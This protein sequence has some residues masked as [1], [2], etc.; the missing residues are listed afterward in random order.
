ML[1]RG[2]IRCAFC[3]A[4]HCHESGVDGSGGSVEK[5]ERD[6]EMEPPKWRESSE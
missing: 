5:A 3:K 1:P 2:R 6:K 4:R